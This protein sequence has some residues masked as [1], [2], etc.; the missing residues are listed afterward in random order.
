MRSEISYEKSESG[1]NSNQSNHL[2]QWLLLSDHQDLINVKILL[3][4]QKTVELFETNIR[5]NNPSLS[6]NTE[7]LILYNLKDVLRL[8]VKN[9]KWD[10]PFQESIMWERTYKT[11]DIVTLK[12]G[13]TER[14]Y[15]NEFNI[16]N[17]Y[18]IWQYYSRGR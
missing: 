5:F 3:K 4:K 8:F 11:V 10:C 7:K 12:S 18:F 13:W 1:K 17:I 16:L 15:W 2:L 14:K 6:C 9:S